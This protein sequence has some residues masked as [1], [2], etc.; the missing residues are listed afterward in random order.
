MRSA[1][2]IITLLVWLPALAADEFSSFV[3]PLLVKHCV[4]CH[5]GEKLKGKVNLK[6]ISDSAAFLTKADLIK[7]MIE[8]IDARDMP[9]EDEPQLSE[10]D[11]TRLLGT[12]KQFLRQSASSAENKPEPIRRLNRFQYNNAIRDLFQLDRDVFHLQEKLMTRRSDYLTDNNGVMPDKVEVECLS[13]TQKKGMQWVEAFPKDLRATHGF[14]NQANQLTLSPLL[15]DSFLQLSVSIL[16]SPDFN[17]QTVGIW[18]DYF[19]APAANADQTKAIRDRLSGFLTLAFRRLV[20]PATLD[21]YVAYTEAK[22]K[23]GR[24]F[25]ESM[26]KVTSA[27]LSSPNFLYRSGPDL[28]LASRLSFFL[29]G[30]GPDR[31][32]LANV[33]QL[34][35]PKVLNDTIDR[36]MADPK[37]ERFLDSFPSQWMQLENVLGA[38]PD[39]SKARYFNLMRNYRDSERPASTQMVLE[40][41]LLFDAVFLENRPVTE[42]LTPSFSYQSEFLRNWYGRRIKLPPFD[43]EKF[44]KEVEA[45]AKRRQALQASIAAKKDEVKKLAPPEKEKRQELNDA[46]RKDQQ[47]LNQ[48][49]KNTDPNRERGIRSR[50]YE[51]EVRRQLLDTK[52]ERRPVADPRYGGIITS[53]AM[54]SMTSGTKRTHPIARGAWVIE[55]ILNDPPPPPPNDVPPLDERAGPKNLTIRERF[56]Q[57]RENPDC[58]GCHSRIDPL[59]FALENF[60]LVGRWRDKYENG[61]DVETGGT[62]WR[63][64]DFTNVTQFKEALV[65]EDR[66]FAKAFTAHL[67]RFALAREL[68]PADTLAID[69]IVEKTAPESF[70]LRSLIREV[71][72]SEPFRRQ[73][74]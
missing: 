65:K 36:M 5:G 62:L 9:P 18:N 60:D 57:H 15:L 50:R 20:Q 72:L 35:Q 11:R 56:A 28:N 26:K 25:T 74:M 3:Q 32:L 68:T 34:N 8:V 61:R 1:V 27:A 14:D 49:P 38:S 13:L 69:A 17:E 55:V 46:I 24:S 16:E 23:E 37:I 73:P 53:A 22:L 19:K 47:A 31:E 52:F 6:E 66:R 7:E 10:G 59:G 51:D 44:A 21:R 12:L 30:S 42:L 67:L 4:R 54:L 45:N 64:Y 70:R 63:K 29:W 41:L 48:I 58:A 71:I 40:P 39:K 2:T 33:K 43:P